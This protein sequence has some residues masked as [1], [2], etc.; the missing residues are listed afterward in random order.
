MEYGPQGSLSGG[1]TTVISGLKAPQSL[2]IDGSGNLYLLDTRNLAEEIDLSAPPSFTFNATPVG[3]QSP[4]LGTTLLNI[5]NANLHLASIVPSTGF[6]LV[7][8]VNTGG[9]AVVLAP[10]ASYNLQAAF[11]PQSKGATTGSLT[12]NDDALAQSE[13]TQTIALSGITGTTSKTVLTW[14]QTTTPTVGARVT[15]TATVTPSSATGTV[16]FLEGNQ[17]IGAA[18][19]LNGGT[20]QLVT[21]AL[22]GGQNLVFSAVYSGDTQVEASTGTMTAN[23]NKAA[24][25]TVLSWDQKTP[26]IAGAQVTLTATV[27]PSAATGTVTFYEGSAQIDLPQSLNGGTAKLITTALT[28]ASNIALKAVYSGDVSYLTSSGTIT[29]T[30]KIPTSTRVTCAVIAS[31]QGAFRLRNSVHRHRQCEVSLNGGSIGTTTLSSGS[32]SMSCPALPAGND[33]LLADYLGDTTH[34]NSSGSETL[35]GKQHDHGV[36]LEP[37]DCAKGRRECDFDC[38]FDSIPRI[39]N[40][41]LL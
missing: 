9:N 31:N 33:V 19:P 11:Q 13:G 10:T 32:A 2:A 18:Q 8:P 36:D 34:G 5:G 23:V 39:G 1:P 16:T 35:S 24:T 28:A 6:A 37:E 25:T 38:H 14:N 22:I 15:F 20:A 26:P 12:L 17:P 21:T 3:S 27:S 30:I 29:K 4:A 7:S 41:D 40:C